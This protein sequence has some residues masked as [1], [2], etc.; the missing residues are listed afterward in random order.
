MRVYR[1]AEARGEI[2]GG[3]FVAGFVG[4]QFALP[5]SVEALR[6]FRKIPPDGR[7]VLVSACDPLN[8]A[9]VLTPGSR[10]PA[11][12]GNLVVFRDGAPVASLQGGEIKWRS[13]VDET[14]REDVTA[15][16]R[17]RRSGLKLVEG[18]VAAG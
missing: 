4:E 8:L 3:R 17:R 5:E 14:I 10:V 12:V 2:R 7:L 1:Q 11:L 13:Q 9:G 15:L 18:D 16:L 6:R